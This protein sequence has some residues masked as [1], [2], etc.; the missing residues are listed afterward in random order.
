MSE[1]NKRFISILYNDSCDAMLL[2]IDYIESFV[3]TWEGISYEK[4]EDGEIESVKTIR[5]NMASGKSYLFG[6]AIEP[7]EDNLIF[8]TLQSTINDLF[9]ALEDISYEV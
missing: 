6:N 9:T 5:I 8:K 1:K 2:N 4:N 3:E 7:D